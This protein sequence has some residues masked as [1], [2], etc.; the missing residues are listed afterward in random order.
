MKKVLV[1]F[2]AL[3]LTLGILPIDQAVQAKVLE[4]ID[5]ALLDLRSEGN[6]DVEVFVKLSSPCVIEQATF[7]GFF[8]T[9]SSE[10][11]N[12]ENK[13]AKMALSSVLSEQ[14]SVQE[15]IQKI[16]GTKSV[17]WMQYVGNAFCTK[18]SLD[19]AIKFANIAQVSKVY[20]IPPM[21]LHRIR[22]KKILNAEKVW[23]EVLDPKGRK[24]DGSGVLC[25]IS[26][27]GIDYTHQDFGSQKTKQGKK[28]IISRDLADGDDDCQELEKVTSHGTACAGIVAADGPGNE[29]GMAPK[30]LLAGYK[31][32]QSPNG[33]LSGEGIFS[34]FEYLIKDKIQ[35]SNNSYGAPFGISANWLSEIQ[36]NAVKAGCVI[37]ASQGNEGSPGR[38]LPYTSGSTAA[39]HDV[40]AVGATDDTDINKFQIVDAPD[41]TFIG[42][43]YVGFFGNTG[44]TFKDYESP[45]EIIDC[46]WGR[47]E[48]FEGLDVKGK[49]ALIQRGPS[50]ELEEK[51]G[52]PLF[53]K[54]KALNAAKAGA[55]MIIVYNYDAG[56]LT[57]ISYA[58][59][60]QNA[61][62]DPNLIPSFHLLKQQGLNIRKQLHTNHEWALG[63]PDQ[64]QNKVLIKIASPETRSNLAS[65]TSS[66]PTY[67]LFLKPDVS[68]PGQSI[69]TTAPFWE[70]DKYTDEFG[71]TSAAGPFVAGCT[72]L[73]VQA[74]PEL[75]P[76]EIKRALMNTATLLKR[77]K[78]NRYVL[79]TSQGQGRVN[80][81]DA[82]KS[83]V[84]IQ[85]PSA[86][87]VAKTKEVRAADFPR[88]WLNAPD[89]AQLDQDVKNS[90]FPLKFYNYNTA[91]SKNLELSYEINSRY[92]D[93]IQVSFSS[94]SV[95]IPKARKNDNPST[96][97]IG[98]TIDYPTT[99]KGEYS[100][101]LIFITDKE[102]GKKYH[103]G[104]CIY[105]N[106]SR[107]NTFAS[108][109]EIDPI[110]FTPNGD[111]ETDTIKFNYTVTN[112]SPVDFSGYA[113]SY[114]ENYVSSL[115]FWAIDQNSEEWVKIY[116]EA[117]VELG[118]HSFE[119]DGKDENGNYILPEGEWQIRVIASGVKLDMTVRGFV[120]VNYY[121]NINNV[122]F[123]ISK[124]TVPPLPTL[125]AFPIPVEPGVGQEFEVAVYLKHANSLKSIQFKMD[126]SGAKDVVKYLGVEGSEFMSQNENNTL[127][128]FDYNEDKNTLFVDI[129]RPLDG[130]SGE[131][132]LMKLRFLAL[133]QNFFDLDFSG[134]LV[135]VIDDLSVSGQERTAKA[136]YKKAEI[137]IQK[138][139]Y[140]RLDFN[141]D[142]QV[143]GKDLVMISTKLG[144]KKGD[145]A[146]YWR[147]DLNYDSLI[148][149]TDFAEFA[150]NYN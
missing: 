109:I 122:S 34:S 49:A 117:D 93:L 48:D 124:S 100:D 137:I 101:I 149:F 139:S 21:K 131:G 62:L 57:S 15:K 55:K 112:G 148:D 143:D 44:K 87:I 18:V 144:T 11:M 26:D 42:S 29:K 61:P 23:N 40:I 83:D 145:S 3:A 102:T 92:P 60:T 12:I 115:S 73:M 65:F 98:V 67:D 14:K 52:K 114:Y 53:W 107:S 35:V 39:S 96:S 129:Q 150:K 91:K 36:S 2:F 9:S 138:Q 33:G 127:Y 110:E 123:E 54:D 63:T 79:L 5:T 8:S 37:V 84:I 19:K 97:F 89:R 47:P 17:R 130:V 128:N 120:P 20:Y 125:F 105:G 82:I 103:V 71:G 45:T 31:I 16:I 4:K 136:F 43:T 75:K 104:I 24:V 64:N 70:T 78:D 116:E 111:G 146:Y 6:P 142:G 147:C 66:G 118:H 119:W 46:G 59:S 58:G 99:I 76:L 51:F 72:A 22:S 30:A 68:A 106:N 25:S 56:K 94:D 38:M 27:T 50:K 134:L 80:I 141:L 74:R 135:S 69:R 95:S 13:F 7:N 28:V 81:Y 88:E 132:Y 90:M 108:G 85:P 10:V 77:A 41:Q 121:N 126:F 140:D 32:A 86:L 113:W 133:E 1:L